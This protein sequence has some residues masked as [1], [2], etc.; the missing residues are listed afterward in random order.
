MNADTKKRATMRIKRIAGQVAGV[1]RMLDDDR[2]CVD[3][4]TQIAAIRSALDALGVELIS[5]HLETC[6]AGHGT[7][8]EHRCAKP[9]SQEQ[10]LAEV[11]AVLARFLK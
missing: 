7:G 3:V 4:L 2:Y 1:Q 10:L 9:M 5:A 8:S 6:V 11:R